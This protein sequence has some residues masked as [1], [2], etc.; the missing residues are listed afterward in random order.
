MISMDRMK[1]IYLNII[2]LLNEYCNHYYNGTPV[3][4]DFV[5]DQVYKEA[6]EFEEA[7]PDWIVPESPTQR[8]GAPITGFKKITR[9][10]P[11]LSLDN[12]YDI[13]SL[14]AWAAGLIKGV[15]EPDTVIGF[16]AEPKF[17]G[18]AIELEYTNG[19]LTTASTRGDG[20]TGE[21]VTSNAKTIQN[22]PIK[23]VNDSFLS[24]R[25]VVRGE[26]LILKKDF[27]IINERR[28]Q[29]GKPRF[30]NAR[31]AASGSLKHL[32]PAVVAARKL[33]FMPYSLDSDCEVFKNTLTL[34][35]QDKLLYSLGF[36]ENNTGY[37]GIDGLEGVIGR[38]MGI[39]ESLPYEIDGCVIK[40]MLLRL[41]EKLGTTGHAPRWAIAYKFPAQQK[42]S[43]V[44]DIGCQVGRTGVITPVAKIEPVFVG[45]VTVSNVTL[46]NE[47]WIKAMD[48][49]VGDTVF[50]ERAGD[51]IPAIAGVVLESRPEGTTPWQM[52]KACPA[53][54]AALASS[55]GVKIFCTN[56][57]CP[58]KSSS[59]INHFV[60]R[61]AFNIKSC[62][63][64]I[65]DALITGGLIT[66]VT[67][68]FLL[69]EDD[70][71][72]LPGFGKKSAQ[73]LISAINDARIIPFDR[74]LYSMGIHG[75]GRSVSKMLSRTFPTLDALLSATR[76]D[77]QNLPDIGSI[78]ADVLVTNQEFIKS[79]ITALELVGVEVQYNTPQT[80]SVP[81]TSV[82]GITGKTFVI[83][84][85][86]PESRDVYKAKL[87]AA[88]AKVS[89]SVSSKTDYLLCG[90]SP[91]SKLGKAKSL[92]IPV[93]SLTDF[94]LF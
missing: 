75:I 93:V 44:L 85:S 49:R 68:L 64:Q 51:V 71:A 58:A 45:G 38:F 86:F 80:G 39:R 37:Y 48:V 82:E 46:H 78:I 66:D 47:E 32:D 25:T 89:G 90:E 22:I 14:M 57:E 87:E 54:G 28:I 56:A 26:V 9:T 29:S 3:V 30:V 2:K 8:V 65:V 91:G 16:S 60:S 19:I 23:L 5:Y 73:R 21:D 6:L 84:G 42:T 55:G 12:V 83:T 34:Q 24:G 52:P 27:E 53:C 7:H 20:Y 88:G 61:D 67:S 35:Q 36:S 15:D 76:E 17:D 92:N 94:T 74:V 72:K 59:L 63:P 10:L 77:F 43:V 40:M 69:K 33:W 70:V 81:A 1:E 11:M 4:S 62:G 50:V 31:N 79:F 41:Q 18:V 13:P